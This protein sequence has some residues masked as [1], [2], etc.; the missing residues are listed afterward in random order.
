MKH[1]ICA[2]LELTRKLNYVCFVDS[3]SYLIGVHK[4]LKSN[5]LLLTSNCFV[6]AYA[7]RVG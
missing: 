2:N 7:N 5:E 6:R 3:V 1:C 4:T